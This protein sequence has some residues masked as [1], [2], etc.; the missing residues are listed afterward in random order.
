MFIIR[1]ESG[2]IVCSWDYRSTLECKGRYAMKRRLA[3][4]PLV[5]SVDNC[6]ECLLI[7]SST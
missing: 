7:I 6:S 1:E 2:R 4:S 5:E 3:Y